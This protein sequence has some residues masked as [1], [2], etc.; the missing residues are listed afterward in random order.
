MKYVFSLLLIF[1][2]FSCST[3]STL[4]I[5][6]RTTMEIDPV[7][8]AGDVVKGEVITAKFNLKNTGDKPLILAE[9]KGSC[10]CTVADYPD[11]PIQPGASAEIMAHVDTD[12]TS[13]GSI[14]K[15][16]R[17]VANTDPSITQVVVKAN[18]RNK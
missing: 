8:D 9:V 16:I 7:Y 18:V 1:V 11:K 12:R 10:T 17:I 13:M 4:D 2:L 5:G 14:K 6:D 3:D 15:S